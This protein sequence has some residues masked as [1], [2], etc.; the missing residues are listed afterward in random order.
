MDNNPIPLPDEESNQIRMLQMRIEK[1]ENELAR[2]SMTSS[3]GHSLPNTKLISDNFLER[4]FAVY[5]HNLVAGLIIGIPIYCLLYLL[6][7]F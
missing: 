6:G 5:G 3:P 2:L 1:L 4:A 7:G